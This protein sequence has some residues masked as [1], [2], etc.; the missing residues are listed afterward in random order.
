MSQ[1]D[2]SAEWVWSAR[3]EFSE[4]KRRAE[5]LEAAAMRGDESTQPVIRPGAEDKDL[6]WVRRCTTEELESE[7]AAAKADMERMPHR[8][9]R[10]FLVDVLECLRVEMARRRAMSGACVMPGATPADLNAALGVGPAVAVTLDESTKE[11]P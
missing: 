11:T 9:T 10:G 8:A 3:A 2:D 6:A 1:G 5:E 7:Y 4:K